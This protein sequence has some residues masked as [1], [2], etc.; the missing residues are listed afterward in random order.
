MAA[1][2]NTQLR[3]AKEAEG[4][5]VVDKILDRR[6]QGN[7]YGYLVTWKGYDDQTWEPR[8]SFTGG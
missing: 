3:E 1:L 5:Y 7:R 2:K 4:E 8:S 6:K